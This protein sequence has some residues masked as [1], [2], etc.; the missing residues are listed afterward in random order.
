MTRRDRE[1]LNKQFRWQNPKSRNNGALIL[2]IAGVFFAG[3]VLGGSLS[4]HQSKSASAAPKV[5]VV[6]SVAAR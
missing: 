4:A 6:A 2:A 5:S 1:L 3:I